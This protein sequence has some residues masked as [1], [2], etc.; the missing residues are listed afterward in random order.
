MTLS[1]ICP[2]LLA[3][4]F[5]TSLLELTIEVLPLIAKVGLSIVAFR[6]DTL[7]PAASHAFE[8]DL[9]KLLRDIG[10]VIVRWV[11]NQIGRAHV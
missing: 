7:T 1:T 9:Q 8:R 11:Y 10:R 4:P 2:L 5:A 6:R 3:T